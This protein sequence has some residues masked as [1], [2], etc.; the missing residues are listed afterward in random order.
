MIEVI[1]ALCAISAITTGTTLAYINHLHKDTEKD[2]EALQVL[3]KQGNNE[4]KKLWRALNKKN[5]S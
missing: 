2:I 3:A 4:H 5:A 1:G